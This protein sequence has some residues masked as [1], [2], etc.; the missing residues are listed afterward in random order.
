MRVGWEYRQSPAELRA[1]GEFRSQWRRRTRSSRLCRRPSSCHTGPGSSPQRQ[2]PAGLGLEG[3]RWGGGSALGHLLVSAGHLGLELGLGEVGELIDSHL[4]CSKGI[5]LLHLD[6]VGVEDVS[7]QLQL[8]LAAVLLS[9]LFT[10][11][12]KLKIAV[13]ILGGKNC[14]QEGRGDHN[15]L[16]D[17]CQRVLT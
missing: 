9:M 14:S 2:L 6:K 8:S 4:P 5:V 15:Q 1:Q 17:E 12:G 11:R 3:A 7:P 16:H 13:S 10:E